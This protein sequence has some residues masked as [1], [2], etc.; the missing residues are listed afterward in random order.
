[1]VDKGDRLTSHT[2]TNDDHRWFGR[3]DEYLYAIPLKL[4]LVL[5]TTSGNQAKLEAMK[6]C[7]V[8]S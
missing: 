6:F 4:W 8:E 1:M 2:H 7:E 5:A 3:H